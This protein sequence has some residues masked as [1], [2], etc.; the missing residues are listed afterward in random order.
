M[1]DRVVTL[2]WASAPWS[3]RAATSGRGWVHAPS[4]LGSFH[5][6]VGC[7]CGLVVDDFLPAP[8]TGTSTVVRH[9]PAISNNGCGTT[10]GIGGRPA[11]S[12][13]KRVQAMMACMHPMVCDATCMTMTLQ[14][15]SYALPALQA[16]ALFAGVYLLRCPSRHPDA[17][18]QMMPAIRSSSSFLQLVAAVGGGVRVAPPPG[19]ADVGRSSSGCSGAPPL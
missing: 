15:W 17:A 12:K 14:Q 2:P 13:S 7:N 18:S 5:D 3:A 4:T 16:S 9:V 1:A 8:A 19:L 10:C 11:D 6:G